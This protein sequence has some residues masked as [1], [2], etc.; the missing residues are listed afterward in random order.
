MHLEIIYTNQLQN[1]HLNKALK[2]MLYVLGCFLSF[3]F[4]N[5]NHFLVDFN[6]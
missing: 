2:I 3:R 5:L 6:L 1:K 4:T